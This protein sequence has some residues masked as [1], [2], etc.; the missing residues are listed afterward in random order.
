MRKLLKPPGLTALFAVS[1]AGALVFT[2]CGNG[3]GATTTTVLP[4]PPPTIQTLVPG[5]ESITVHWDEDEVADAVTF[6]AGWR[7]SGYTG[8]ITIAT[9]VVSG[10]TITGLTN[11]QPYEVFLRSRNAA[12]AYGAWSAPSTATP[13][14]GAGPGALATPEGLTLNVSIAVAGHSP[15]LG[16]SWSEVADRETFTVFAFTDS[17]SSDPA[18]AY[19]R[20]EGVTALSLNIF[21]A[22]FSFTGNG[23]E[24]ILPDDRPFWFRVQAIGEEYVSP[25]SQ[26]VGPVWNAP[27]QSRLPH[28]PAGAVNNPLNRQVLFDM[29]HDP[30]IPV[31]MIDIR[32]NSERMIAPATS[33]R[34]EGDLHIRWPNNQAV[35]NDEGGTYAVFHNGVIEAW[36]NTIANLTEAQRATLD[37]A[38]EYRDIRIFVF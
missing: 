8:A 29:F 30:A 18:V 10:H 35:I 34:I 32:N 20:V 3:N 26:P 17:A 33:G 4:P 38:L 14:A 28:S 11:G 16:F 22:E 1:L 13:I 2:G 6:D 24:A 27:T 5:D 21:T 15:P 37:P 25:L 36:E 7:V 23:T 12:Q 31:V 9:G 19:A